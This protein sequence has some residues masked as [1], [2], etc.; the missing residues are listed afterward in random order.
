MTVEPAELSGSKILIT[1]VTGQ[2]ALP[3]ARH[4]AAQ[5]E[6]WGMGRFAKAEARE[7]IEALGVK[8]VAADLGKPASLGQLPDDFDYVLNYAVVH[9]DDFPHDLAVN[10][11]G[12]G[13]LMSRCRKAKAFLHCSSTAVY[14]YLGHEPRR[15]DAPLGDNHRSLMPTY[16]ISKIV[17]ESVARFA[18][19]EFGVPTV[20][21]RLSVPYGDRGG[22]PMLHLWQMQKGEPITVHPEHPNVYNL[23]H[24]DDHAAKLPYLLGAAESTAVT[25]NFGGSEPVS[26]ESWCG[27]IGEL[28][29]LTPTWKDEPTAFGSLQIDTERMHRLIGETRVD[30]REGIRRMLQTLAPD[31]LL[32]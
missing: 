10:G 3:V 28:T 9:G 27:W 11:E 1:G 8:T 7:E 2:V 19:A 25:V 18:A 31:A 21:A 14:E 15:E 29:G 12:I 23:L 4:F 20:I 26:I 22:W 24:E 32:G 16:S 5:A 13:H 30:W 6:V 17:G